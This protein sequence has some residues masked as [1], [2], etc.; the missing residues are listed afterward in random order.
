[1]NIEV[2]IDGRVA[3]LCVNRPEV[4]NALDS[5]TVQEM[6]AALTSLIANNDIGAIIIT[7]AGGKAFAAGADIKEMAP[8]SYMDV[9]KSDMFAEIGRA[10]V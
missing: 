9:Y 5:A 7:G 6:T 1:M 2:T 8:Q 10:H 4:R 3:T